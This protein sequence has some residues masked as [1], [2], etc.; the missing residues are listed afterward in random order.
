[1]SNRKRA[2]A[3]PVSGAGPTP[4]FQAHHDTL[5][6]ELTRERWIEGWRV[7]TR[8]YGLLDAGL[9]GAAEYQA[10]LRWQADYEAGA[11]GARQGGEAVRVDEAPGPGGVTD[12]RL[13][14]LGRLRAAEQ[15]IGR[16]AA[17]HLIRCVGQDRP[18]DEL[19]R[20]AGVRRH[21]SRSWTCAAL[22]RLLLHYDAVDQVGRQGSARVRSGRA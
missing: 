8:L 3:P 10:G 11:C 22:V 2:P 19:D 13:D 15:A 17:G 16:E 12:A 18:W 5:P 7:N 1:V 6:P 14:A 4:E 9:I 20:Q 21:T